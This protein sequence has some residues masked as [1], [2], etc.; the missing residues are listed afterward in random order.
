MQV[1]FRVPL[2]LLKKPTVLGWFFSPIPQVLAHFSGL[3]SRACLNPTSNE[4]YSSAAQVLLI[5]RR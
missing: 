2:P 1:R 5:A 4:P 3:A